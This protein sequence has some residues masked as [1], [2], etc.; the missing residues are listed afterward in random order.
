MNDSVIY[1]YTN[2]TGA[3]IKQRLVNLQSKKRDAEINNDSDLM[4]S[5]ITWGEYNK[6][7]IK[8]SKDYEQELKY[9]TQKR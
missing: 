2:Y 3:D 5:R 8:I 7:N 4:S 6:I 9:L 1:F